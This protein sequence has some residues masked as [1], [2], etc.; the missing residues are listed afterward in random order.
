[1]VRGK[2]VSV[3]CA[4]SPGTGFRVYPYAVHYHQHKVLSVRCIV[5]KAGNARARELRREY[6]MTR[7]AVDWRRVVMAKQNASQLEKVRLEEWRVNVPTIGNTFIL[8]QYVFYY[9]NGLGRSF[10]PTLIEVDSQKGLVSRS[11]RH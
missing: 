5:F 11:D 2:R 3:A 8:A 9:L 6:I 4:T 10:N 1:M 7:A